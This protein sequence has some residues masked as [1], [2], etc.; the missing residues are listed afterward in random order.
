MAPPQ[1]GLPA[2]RPLS[3]SEPPRSIQRGEGGGA[4]RGSEEGWR[5]LLVPR[6]RGASREGADRRL[7]GCHRLPGLPLLGQALLL[8]SAHLQPRLRL[9]K[10]PRHPAPFIVRITQAPALGFFRRRPKSASPRLTRR[11]REARSLRR[12]LLRSP[13]APQGPAAITSG[14]RWRLRDPRA[15]TPGAGGAKAAVLRPP[16]CPLREHVLVPAPGGAQAEAKFKF[17]PLPCLE[18]ASNA[19]LGPLPQPPQARL[20]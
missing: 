5:C 15:P 2:P 20:K 10:A 3:G 4:A 16:P 6:G 14:L 8:R 1:R 12:H 7:S 13:A 17:Q 11:E 9:P 18:I 19:A